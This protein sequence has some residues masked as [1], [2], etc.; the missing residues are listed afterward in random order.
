M[1]NIKKYVVHS[2]KKNT[3]FK[4]STDTVNGNVQQVVSANSQYVIKRIVMPEKPFS[5]K[6]S[7]VHCCFDELTQHFLALNE[8]EKELTV[9]HFKQPSFPQFTVSLQ[10]VCPSPEE[11]RAPLVQLVRPESSSSSSGCVLVWPKTGHVQYWQ[12]IEH[13]KN[14]SSTLECSRVLHYKLDLKKDE[15]IT[16][17]VNAEPACFI[18]SLDSGRQFQLFLRDAVGHPSVCHRALTADTNLFSLKTW[19]TLLGVQSSPKYSIIKAGAVKGVNE[20]FVYTL[21]SNCNLQ[22]WEVSCAFT[23]RLLI[24]NDMQKILQTAF[25]GRSIQCATFTCHDVAVCLKDP[26]IFSIIVSWLN[27]DTQR[28]YAIVS[29][30]LT[31]SFAL[32]VQGIYPICLPN[33]SVFSR[34]RLFG[35]LTRGDYYCSFDNYVIN[36]ISVKGEEKICEESILI[37][38]SAETRLVYVDCVNGLVS[39]AESPSLIL[40]TNHNGIFKILSKE[41]AVFPKFQYIASVFQQLLFQTAA[42]KKQF[43]FSLKPV[44]ELFS[45]QDIFEALWKLLRQGFSVHEGISSEEESFLHSDDLSKKSEHQRDMFSSILE[46]IQKHI[47]LTPEHTVVLLSL[48]LK[49]DL[50][51]ELLKISHKK[52][53]RSVFFKEFEKKLTSVFV[54]SS[55]S[56]DLSYAKLLNQLSYDLKEKKDDDIISKVQSALDANLVYLTILRKINVLAKDNFDALK[57]TNMDSLKELW[58]VEKQFVSLILEHIQY[59]GKLCVKVTYES[60]DELIRKQMNCNLEDIVIVFNELYVEILAEKLQLRVF[61]VEQ[62]RDN[63][64]SYFA[65]LKSYETAFTLLQ[66]TDNIASIVALLMHTNLPADIFKRQ[67]QH[68]IDKYGEAFAFPFFESLVENH[69]VSTL[70]EDYPNHTNLIRKYLT[71]KRSLEL[72]WVFEAMQEN[73]QNASKL[74]QTSTSQQPDLSVKNIELG[75]AKLFLLADEHTEGNEIR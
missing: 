60:S 54:S 70:L 64:I 72:L 11:T 50:Y 67:S 55:Q 5:S 40:V 57:N 35:N 28:L 45:E 8:K 30:R 63:W 47:T 1:L 52:R 16:T 2:K 73:F 39:N 69:K 59:L 66:D 4:I 27:V 58:I 43:T 3:S 68:Y 6:Q 14:S 21:S 7:E 19:T 15:I 26:Y 71:E 56:N 33:Q 65:D 38:H 9:I 31:E 42:A 61:D 25:A 23:S 12:N 17:L 29:C 75:L 34:P 41:N 13:L 53:E 44:L 37:N 49:F 32:S 48:Y 10:S 36:L 74:L 22:V 62:N 18:I 20:R 51:V 24:Q 46:Y